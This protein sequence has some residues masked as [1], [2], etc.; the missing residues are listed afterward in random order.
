VAE[1]QGNQ[2][3]SANPGTARNSENRVDPNDVQ[4]EEHDNPEDYELRLTR[5][6]KVAMP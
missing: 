6:V 5:S 4:K 1:S 3:Y 2:K